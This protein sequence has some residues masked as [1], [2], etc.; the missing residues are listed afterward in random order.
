M[1]AY[2]LVGA[3][4]PTAAAGSLFAGF[5]SVSNLA[6][7]ASYGSGGWLYDHGME[8]AP[9]RA[10]QRIVFGIGGV[11]GDKL[12]LNVLIL[13]G[14]VAYFACFVALRALPE[15]DATLAR[16]IDGAAGPQRWLA[17]PAGVRRGVNGGAVVLGAALLA[18]LLF[19]WGIDPVSSVMG[20]FLGVC[21]V[22]KALLD[23]LLRHRNAIA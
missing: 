4:V 18:G 1:T 19:R 23:A 20:T 22:R 8:L 17:L 13:I 21:L 12:S 5:M 9:L 10:V 11:A 2:S 6:Y 3:V 14:S 15:R 16:D 7:A